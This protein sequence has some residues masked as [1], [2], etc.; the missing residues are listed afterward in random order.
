MLA[1]RLYEK[2]PVMLYDAA[3]ACNLALAL[4][5][6]ALWLNIPFLVSACSC[7]VA[8]DQLLWYVDC[9]SYLIR[10]RFLVGVA[11]Y[12]AN[13]NTGEGEGKA[14][15]KRNSSRTEKGAMDVLNVNVSWRC[16]ADVTHHLPFLGLFDDKPCIFGKKQTTVAAAAPAAAFC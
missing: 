4:T 13:K 14:D 7:W 2:G 15:I 5:A 6:V 1:S 3:W 10:G 9:I 11:K 8:V 12:I 16:W